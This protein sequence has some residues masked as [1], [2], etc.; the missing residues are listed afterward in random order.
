M[1]GLRTM[2]NR[3]A[4]GAALVFLCLSTASAASAPV[5]YLPVPHHAAVILN[6]GSTNSPGYRIVVAPDGSAQWVMGATRETAQL[7]QKNTDALFG[8][9]KA[10]MP[11]SQLQSAHCMKSASFGTSTFAYW[12]HQRSTDLQCVADP[13]ATALYSSI[14][15]V[16]LELGIAKRVIP[17]PNEPRRPIPESSPSPT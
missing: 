2:I 8:D 11:L 9:L 17:M 10:A 4:G 7:S 15:A 13:H 16:I 3:I 14:Q 12:E 5:P 1:E 6:T